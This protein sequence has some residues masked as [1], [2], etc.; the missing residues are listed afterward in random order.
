M[1]GCA[2]DPHAGEFA[3]IALQTCTKGTELDGVERQM[4]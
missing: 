2:E 4:R 3:N 1:P